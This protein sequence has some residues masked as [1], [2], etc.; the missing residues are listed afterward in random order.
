MASNEPLISIVFPEFD[1]PVDWRRGVVRV[2]MRVAVNDN[3][4]KG[5]CYAAGD[6]ERVMA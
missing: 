2:D 4:A 5:N 1:V 3:R 6:N